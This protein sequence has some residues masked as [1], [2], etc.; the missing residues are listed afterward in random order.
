M[1]MH[2]VEGA[3]DEGRLAGEVQVAESGASSVVRDAGE[4]V[5]FVQWHRPTPLGRDRTATR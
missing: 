4:L 1:A 2:L 3:L 5:I